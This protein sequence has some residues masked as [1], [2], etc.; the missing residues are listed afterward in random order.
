MTV[1]A[2]LPRAVR[3]A[4]EWRAGGVRSI[5]AFLKSEPGDVPPDDLLDLI[6]QEILLLDPDVP[7]PDEYRRRFPTVADQVGALFAMN[8]LLDDREE[9]TESVDLPQYRV[10][11]RLGRGAIGE[12]FRARD[13]VLGRPLAVK[14]LRAEWQADPA[15]AERFWDEACTTAR[16][17][18]PGVAPVYEAG[19]GDGDRPYIAMKLIEGQTLAFLLAERASPAE[20]LDSFI[21]IFEQVCQ[22]VAYAHSR[23]VIHRDLKP[24]NVMVGAFGEVQ[25]MD[26]GLA[27]EVGSP[28]RGVRNEP[29]PAHPIPLSAVDTPHMQ[30]GRTQ[31]GE[32]IGTPAYAAPEQTRGDHARVST[33][34]DV[35][36]LGAILCEILTGKPPFASVEA[37]RAGDVG[38]AHARLG[39]PPG[40]AGI[41]PARTL[42]PSKDSPG[43]ASASAGRMPAVPGGGSAAQSLN[44]L[45]VACLSA[46]PQDRPPDGS[47]VA[48]AVAAYRASQQERLRAAELA[49]ARAA[50]ERTARHRAELLRLIGLLLLV[51]AGLGAWAWFSRQASIVREV[52]GATN[53]GRALRDEMVRVGGDPVLLAA[54][55]RSAR[56]AEGLLQG[57]AGRADLRARV[58]AL[59]ADL[60]RDGRDPELVRRLER[61][62]LDLDLPGARDVS[63]LDAESAAAFRDAGIDIEGNPSDVAEQ[64]RGRAVRAE[65]VALID[66][67]AGLW[68][69]IAPEGPRADHLF[70]ITRLADPDDRRNAIRDALWSGHVA[71]LHAEA[72]TSDLPAPLWVTVGT[73][74]ARRPSHA[75]VGLRILHAAR[76]RYPGDFWANHNLAFYLC[77]VEQKFADAIPYFT[78][79]AALRP[80]LARVRVNLGNAHRAAGNLPAAIDAHRDAIAL[81][82]DLAVAHFNLANALADSGDIEAAAS[83]AREVV[84][85]DPAYRNGYFRLG[86]LLAL[87]G[88]RADAVAALELAVKTPADPECRAAYADALKEVGRFGDAVAVLRRLKEELK[89]APQAVRVGL[90]LREAERMVQVEAEVKRIEAG[91]PEPRTAEALWPTAWACS[92]TGH[93]VLAVR[94]ARQALALDPDRERRPAGQTELFHVAAALRIGD[95]GTALGWLRDELDFQSRDPAGRQAVRLWRQHRDLAA[96]RDLAQLPEGE[97]AAWAELWKKVDAFVRR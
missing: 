90:M 62:R 57:V 83:E 30:E 70:A 38:P 41:L 73:M 64:I 88:A 51:A 86:W 50:A 84:R 49:A 1:P 29:P 33:A 94:L 13:E 10:E 48:A 61:A 78:A 14:V 66:Y 11:G 79:A 19:Y 45:A 32:M 76:R 92:L 95:R 75:A 20:R 37:A 91:G 97:R 4:R 23:G 44:A 22:T 89:G 40:T 46:D 28:E 68:A 85:I 3:F 5:E 59:L 69:R 2:S 8:A 81:Q 7:P 52:E 63:A 18:H 31:A 71:P 6:Q 21:G 24:A 42:G 65:L 16:L 67:W 56:R 54:A 35:F 77:Q 43:D 93:D 53:E 55:E 26:W 60:E 74:L 47:A 80:G 36:G 58:A 12:V 17:Q 15:A 82:P 39:F 87:I 27:K 96:G 34:S 72:T 25:V 9:A